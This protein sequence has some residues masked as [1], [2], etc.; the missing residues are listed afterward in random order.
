MVR[1]R[2]FDQ[3]DNVTMKTTN[4]E[5]LSLNNQS[6]EEMDDEESSS[7]EGEEDQDAD[8]ESDS[9]KDDSDSV[10]SAQE[11]N[12][13]GDVD[14]DDA[15]DADG[16][17]ENQAHSESEFVDADHLD[18]D[19][20]EIIAGGD[21]RAG[22]TV[23]HTSRPT[24]M[25]STV[26]L[27]DEYE[28]D[29]SDE[30]DLRNTIGNIPVEWYDQYDH[31]GYDQLGKKII[32]PKDVS[33]NEV[34]HFLSKIE[35]PHYWRTVKNKFT[36]ENVIL[37][38]KDAEI[39]RRISKGQYPDPNY[40]PYPEF[41]D[42]FTYS[43]MIHPV[44]NRPEHK[45][46]FIPSISEKRAISKLVSKIKREWQKPKVEGKPK[47]SKFDFNYDIWEKESKDESRKQ[48]DRR[49]KYIPAPK[50]RLPGHQESYNPPPEYLPPDFTADKPFKQVPSG[51]IPHKF[52]NLRSVPFYNNYVKEQ[53][54]RCLDLYLCPRVTKMKSQVNPEDLIPKLPRPNDLQPFPTVQSIVFK[55][56]TD[57]VNSIT[58]EPRGEFFAS[59]SDD[60]TVCIW[61]TL[62]GRCFKK[63]TFDSPVCAVA[64]SPDEKKPL[65]AVAT[66]KCI[67]FLTPGV[68]DKLATSNVD[69]F[70]K[71]LE[72]VEPSDTPVSS[73][74]FYH[75]TD[76]PWNEG[77]RAVIEHKFDVKQLHWHYK[78]DYLSAVLPS[79]ANRSVVIHQLTK[80]RSQLPFS[81][82]HGQIVGALFHPNRPFFFVA[83]KQF[84]RIY[85]LT[86]QELSKKLSAN[87]KLISSMDIH[88]KGT[89]L[90]NN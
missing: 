51:F 31:I 72:S 90:S 66:G 52:A 20:K 43:Q 57:V 82:S 53:F 68:C 50:V 41:V 47:A 34:D 87:C 27:V 23:N 79:G 17:G 1:R 10:G 39:A 13:R 18:G 67:V 21:T 62:T 30:E 75:E 38:D 76:E 83:T 3:Q 32:K 35:D 84:I 70:F 89:F 12:I 77:H 29:S 56:H 4:D 15:A 28:Y 16:D 64:W 19:D 61:E 11:F 42:F 55:G 54:E 59:A 36:G 22:E 44:T 26:A 60:N 45:A 63:F 40:N 5:D 73:W 14:D 2:G 85:D 69:E 78:G 6:E 46:S 71:S 58:F 86:K 37:T 49:R 7:D 8:N 80:K 9:D 25:S 74:K 24:Q 33:D 81:K 65:L 88:P 48:Q